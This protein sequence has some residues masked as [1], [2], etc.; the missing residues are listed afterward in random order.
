MLDNV[1]DGYGIK[2]AGV[3]FGFA[4]RGTQNLQPPFLSPFGRPTRGFNSHCIPTQL[5]RDLVE[6][7]L[8][9]RDR[10][11]IEIYPIATPAMLFHAMQKTAVAT[12]DIE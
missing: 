9:L 12:A 5:V 4:Q 1:P 8:G 3:K 6:R 7:V 11:C 2:S 10:L